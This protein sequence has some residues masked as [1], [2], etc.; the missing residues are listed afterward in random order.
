MTTKEIEI[1]KS[2]PVVDVSWLPWGKEAM[3]VG[4]RHKGRIVGR[5]MVLKSVK[6]PVVRRGLITHE[7]RHA[8]QVLCEGWKQPRRYFSSKKAYIGYE[9]P[10][11]ADQAI[12]T[13][14]PVED[15]VDALAGGL[16]WFKISRE[17]ALKALNDAELHCCLQAALR[18]G[19][20]Y[21]AAVAK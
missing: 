18:A 14:R 12:E 9:A 15:Y 6:D 16:P 20:E 21:Q 13:G 7:R 1:I 19:S 11:Y 4:F 17:E 2:I 3:F 8:F 5:I 10:A